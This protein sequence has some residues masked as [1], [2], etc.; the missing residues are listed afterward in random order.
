[1]RGK[2]GSDICEH[3]DVLMKL[4]YKIFGT[5]LQIKSMTK[6]LFA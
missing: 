6:T 1:M 3:L 2:E 5:L 4:P